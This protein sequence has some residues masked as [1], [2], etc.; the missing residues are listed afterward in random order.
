MS[1]KTS[2][3]IKLVLLDVDGV[4]TDGTIYISEHGE[5]FKSFDVQDGLAIELLRAHGI[6]TGIISGKKSPALKVRCEQ[7][8][9]DFIEMGC[10]HK[11][12]KLADL[13]EQLSISPK[14][15]AFCGDDVLDLD[16]MEQ[17]AVSAAP[18]DAHDLVLHSASWISSK[19]GGKSMVRHFV[20]HLLMDQTGL[21]LKDIYSPL[22]EKIR[23]NDLKGVEQ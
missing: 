20:D 2:S 5:Y 6:Y 9:F 1:L 22:L 4:M 19:P 16:I 17:C 3:P 23:Q 14:N 8:G 21:S 10:K 7:L 15:V 18:A 13:C 12:P 11:L